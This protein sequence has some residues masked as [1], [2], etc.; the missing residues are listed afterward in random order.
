MYEFIPDGDPG[1]DQTRGTGSTGWHPDSFRQRGWKAAYRASPR[2]VSV[3]WR[4]SVDKPS[5]ASVT[6]PLAALDDAALRYPAIQPFR[7]VLG[8][9]RDGVMVWGGI[10]WNMRVDLQERTLELA[11]RDFLSYYETNHAYGGWSTARGGDFQSDILKR[12]ALRAEWG[13]QTTTAAVTAM[14]RKREMSFLENEFKPSLDVM[15]DLADNIGGFFFRSEAW[16]STDGTE[17]RH[18]IRNT[19]DRKP[20]PAVDASGKELPALVDGQTCEIQELFLNGENIATTAYTIGASGS[21]KTAGVW[22][23]RDN[24]ALRRQFPQRDVVNTMGSI[25][26]QSTLDLHGDT[27]LRFGATGIVTPRVITYPDTFDPRDFEPNAG[28]KIRLVS[29]NEFMRIDGW[30]VITEARVV[31]DADGSDRCEL[32]LVQE[33]LFDETG[34]PGP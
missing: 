33:E 19:A 14:P 25:K 29:G 6:I 15:Q 9:V 20:R 8:I 3:G 32:S 17:L 28:Q 23:R 24:K 16:R 34:F 18:G 22:S 13:I 11:G 31:I 4:R 10:V 21:D 5:E 12:M 7:T 27:A 30:Y 1:L 2:F 26:H